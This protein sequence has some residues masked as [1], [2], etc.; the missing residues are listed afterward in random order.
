M[1]AVLAPVV[2]VA[3]IIFYGLFRLLVVPE[4]PAWIAP[5]VFSCAFSG[6]QR[7]LADC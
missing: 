5:R 1:P 2:T 3:F 6:R 4:I 7:M